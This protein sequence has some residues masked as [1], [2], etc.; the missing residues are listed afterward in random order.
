MVLVEGALA[1]WKRRDNKKIAGMPHMTDMVITLRTNIMIDAHK[2]SGI[3]TIR[4]VL[5]FP[6]Q[7]L[8]WNVV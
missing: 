4:C 5:T 7:R 3:D 1:G 6:L 2:E 8:K